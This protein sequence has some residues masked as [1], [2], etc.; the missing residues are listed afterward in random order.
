[1]SAVPLSNWDVA[2]A[3]SLLIINAVLS[4]RLQLRLEKTLTIAAIRMV[5]QLS[6]VALVLR[7]LFETVSPWLTAAVAAIMVLF[8]GYEAMA[9]QE[10]RFK[11]GWGYGIGTAA[12]LFASITVTLFALTTQVQPEPWYN[13][14]YA[15]PLLG[16]ILGNCMT[17]VA[18]GL[19]VLL[20]GAAKDRA[21]IEA[22]IALGYP[23][24]EAFRPL[25][26]DAARNGMIPI[27]NSMAATGL[28]FLPGM[29]TG[30][31][32]AGADPG[33]AAKYQMLIIFLIAGG[34][35]LGVMTAVLA[36][37]RR[38]TDDRH[39][40]RLDRLTPARR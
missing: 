23:C 16:M 33:Q 11:G 39:R 8:A 1:M 38:L 4:I 5:V 31:I 15:I 24:Q 17:G 18:L 34:T 25:V 19:S 40:L 10:R 30:Q 3:G 7:A 20:T 29:M 6:L 32:L 36:G 27:I 28:V 37:Q 21:R 26:R 13:P 35:A 9:R 2:L 22:M 12:M 14:R